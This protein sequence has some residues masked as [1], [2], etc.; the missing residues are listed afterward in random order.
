MRHN[1]DYRVWLRYIV[2]HPWRVILAVLLATLVL[3]AEIPHLKIKAS[4][5]EVC[6]RDSTEYKN[7]QRF[8]SQF[9]G[10]EYIE[11][12][13]RGQNVFDPQTFASIRR[14]SE[15]FS[16]IPGVLEVISLPRIKDQ[17]DLLDEWSIP[18]FEEKLQPV[19]L[20]ENCLYNRGK[21]ATAF[22]VILEDIRAEEPIVRAI[23]QILK[24]ESERTGL[25]LYQI[26]MPVLSQALM[27][28]LRKDFSFL[29]VLA[30]ALML[31][32]LLYLFR[33]W[34]LVLGPVVCVVVALAWTFGVMAWAD[35]PV[36]ALSLIVPIFILAVGTAYCLH[37]AAEYLVE[38]E[39]ADTP[40]E[41]AYTTMR[42]I[43]LPTVLAVASTLLGLSVLIFNSM[44]A[45]RAFAAPA[46]VGMLSV[47]LL[48]LFLLPAILALI[49]LPGPEKVRTKPR[50]VDRFL[51]GVIKANLQHQKLTISIIALI[52][53][54]AAAGIPRV[55]LETNP[56]KYFDESLPV[57]KHFTDVYKDLSG[58]FPVNIVVDAGRE[59]YFLKPEN[60]AK[61]AH[62]QEYL[63]SITGVDKTVSFADYM[64]LARYS[65]SDFD[66]LEYALPETETQARY[67]STLYEM[68]LG[69]DVAGRFVSQDY[70]KATIFMLTHLISSRDWLAT[71]KRIEDYWRTHFAA[72]FD[73]YP[74]SMGV[75]VAHS[76][77]TV[78]HGLVKSLFFTIGLVFVIMFVLFLSVKA[79]LV[80]LLPNMFPIL[81]NFGVMGW[82]G[83]EL[84]M[85]TGVISTIALGLAIDDTIHYMVRYNREFR[86]DLNERR[87]LTATLSTVGRPI[88]FTTVTI[89]TGFFV[90]TL[91]DFLPTSTFG[92]LMMVTMVSA[93][94]GDL[95][96]L[97]SLMTRVELVTIWDM[98]Q[99]KLGK[100]PVKEFPLFA[101]LSRPQIQSLLM[102]ADIR[103]FPPGEIRLPAVA[104]GSSIW[105]VVSGEVV[106]YHTVG[107]GDAGLH[108]SR[109]R[110]ATLGPGEVIGQSGEESWHSSEITLLA[111]TRTE[112]LQ[113]N[114]RVIKRF[115]WLFPLAANRFI[116]N[117]ISVIS[118]RLRQTTEILAGPG[119]TD[120]VTG[121]PNRATFTRDLQKELARADRYGHSVSVVVVEIANLKEINT[122]EGFHTGDRVLAEAAGILASRIRP[123]DTL[124]RL[125]EFRFAAFL[126]CT[127]EKDA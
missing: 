108:G 61:L 62:F 67:M 90:L 110:I 53:L 118:A 85:N 72:D 27:D 112:L 59:G 1:F 121:L 122:R 18:Q 65:A 4:V 12:V 36:S 93:L 124:C 76:N 54:A 33:S 74:T 102:A 39:K 91:S 99:V 82:L 37:V 68:M 44:D 123:F 117:L 69:P 94:V 34:R 55:K 101:G 46:C 45:I 120:D 56:S 42:H 29:P 109:I 3:G 58:S 47:M 51:R 113:I 9:G 49:P 95:F 114:A 77:K 13:A 60:L 57:S 70:S 71:E 126:V 21:T 96:L 19:K 41:A 32:I 14:L 7:Y 84:S 79:A 28:N 115:Q 100:E 73:M 40:A 15:K 97:P 52:S 92:A 8:L 87:A 86:K 89:T 17:M 78:T 104:G 98:L 127:P 88:V 64:K 35:K 75:V 116:F 80:T 16:A 119:Y 111:R 43:R 66:R 50:L 125:D 5:Y 83:L 31:G 24:E 106:M 22:L 48:I 11:V 30:L 25:Y 81:L 105:S 6:I 63:M 23:D 20:F 38:A 2:D 103:E 10:G 107:K 26:G